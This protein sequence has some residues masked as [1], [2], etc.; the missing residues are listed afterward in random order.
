MVASLK[1]A[2]ANAPPSENP[3]HP[4][5]TV[6]SKNRVLHVLT[7]RLGSSKTFGENMIFMLNRAGPLYSLIP[8]AHTL[9]LFVRPNCGRF[10]HAV[11]GTQNFVP[12]IHHQRH[13]RVF[14]HQRSLRACRRLPPGA[15]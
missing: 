7:R 4:S 9:T 6:E 5:K 8:Y 11:A 12:F 13:V 15:R 1:S 2:S 10:M 14:L 3:S